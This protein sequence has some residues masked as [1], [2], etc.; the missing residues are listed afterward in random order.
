MASRLP[1]QNVARP[2]L[3]DTP[4]S[5]SPCP[6]LSSP[7]ISAHAQTSIPLSRTNKR[8]TSIRRSQSLHD[9]ALAGGGMRSLAKALSPSD[10]QDEFSADLCRLLIEL[11]TGWVAA[12]RPGLHRFI[13][14]WVGPEVVVQDRRILSGKVLDQE[15]QK[16]EDAIHRKV[17]GKL[18]T[19]QCDG[20]ENVAKS[21]IVS[22]VMSV[23][24]VVSKDGRLFVKAHSP[25]YRFDG[26]ALMEK[27]YHGVQVIAW[28]TDDGPD[29]KKMRRLL[30][31]QFP[32]LITL[33]CWVHQINLT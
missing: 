3:R 27:Q 16:V 5:D 33:L 31:A 25:R 26:I 24:N 11:N 2:L 20:W 9:G 15:V 18:A 32:C 29:G 13:Q 30:Q 17:Q 19:G 8:T 4:T 14:K 21:S 1:P 10:L 12:D 6:E 28:C 22:S 7:A 23:E